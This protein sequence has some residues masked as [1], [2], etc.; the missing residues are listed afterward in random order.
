MVTPKTA[1]NDEEETEIN[2]PW[3]D[4]E[5]TEDEPSSAEPEDEELEVGDDGAEIATADVHAENV[6]VD[7]DGETDLKTGE[8][9]G[10]LSDAEIDDE[11]EEE[12]VQEDVETADVEEEDIKSESGKFGFD[13]KEDAET[14]EDEDDE[15]SEDSP[16]GG[17]DD[18]D[19]GGEIAAN[20]NAGVASLGVIGIEDD[21][22]QEDLREDFFKAARDFRLGYYGEQCAEEYVLSEDD[23]DVSPVWGLVVSV[24]ICGTIFVLRRPDTEEI[25]KKAREQVEKI[26]SGGDS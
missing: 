22:M 13:E 14:A 7:S 26:G 6:E 12:S 25:Q 17:L 19:E 16:L 1:S 23:G 11:D 15:E 10:D 24:A 21:D 5:E 8:T 20:I 9:S 4:D 3:T 18:L 2:N